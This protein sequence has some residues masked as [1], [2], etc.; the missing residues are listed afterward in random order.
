MNPN[1][2]ARALARQTGPRGPVDCSE[3]DARRGEKCGL[4]GGSWVIIIGSAGRVICRVPL[5]DL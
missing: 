4:L 3:P 1:S 5:R 2:F